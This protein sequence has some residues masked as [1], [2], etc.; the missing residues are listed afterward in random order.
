MVPK[1]VS[2]TIAIV[3]GEGQDDEVDEILDRVISY[4][5]S[6]FRLQVV[7]TPSLATVVPSYERKN[8]ATEDEL[9]QYI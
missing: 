9:Y 3:Q 1:R 4:F 5:K 7:N 6:L 8:F 2:K